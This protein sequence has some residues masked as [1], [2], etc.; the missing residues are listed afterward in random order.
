MT[1]LIKQ[2]C[3]WTAALP[4][5]PKWSPKSLVNLSRFHIYTQLIFAHMWTIVYCLAML[6]TQP[7][8]NL[9][10]LHAHTLSRWLA[11]WK[12]SSD[13]RLRFCALFLDIT[14][15][16]LIALRTGQAAPTPCTVTRWQ[17]RVCPLCQLP[18]HSAAMQK[19]AQDPIRCPMQA[20]RVAG[21]IWHSFKFGRFDLQL[22]R[23]FWSRITQEF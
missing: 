8:L 10:P 7:L 13:R 3:L 4:F 5:W 23:L 19:R 14:S 20:G 9:W 6:L 16:W 12:A 2:M 22:W 11:I 18:P 21:D 1:Q 15:V 17:G